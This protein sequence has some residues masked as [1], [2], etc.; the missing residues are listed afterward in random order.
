MKEERKMEVLK[1]I[2]SSIF[3]LINDDEFDIFEKTILMNSILEIFQ[4]EAF[5]LKRNMNKSFID[6]MVEKIR[7]E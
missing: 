2:S 4:N 6:P 1:E 5:R 3:K 7:K